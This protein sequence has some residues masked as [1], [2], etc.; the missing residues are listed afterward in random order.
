MLG[1]S[2]DEVAMHGVDA[3]YQIVL[4]YTKI[5]CEIYIIKL[6]AILLRWPRRCRSGG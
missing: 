1:V 3:F 2:A 5:L 6:Y 4:K